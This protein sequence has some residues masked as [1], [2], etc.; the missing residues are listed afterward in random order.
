MAACGGHTVGFGTIDWK[1]RRY[2]SPLPPGWPVSLTDE[3]M[4]E[5]AGNVFDSDS[6]ICP[7]IPARFTPLTSVT[8]C[9]H[10]TGGKF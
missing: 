9:R 2:P 3:R 5:P 6:V 8:T 4:K 7:I 1:A 10:D